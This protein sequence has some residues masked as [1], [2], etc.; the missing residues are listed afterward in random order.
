M[1]KIKCPECGCDI[2]RDAAK[3]PFC[4]FVIKKENIS[5][6]NN[7]T[8]VRNGG[9]RINCKI[10]GIVA[11]IASVVLFACAFSR[12]NNSEY[13]F[14]KEYYEDCMEG[15]DNSKYSARTEGL[16]FSGAYTMIA[17]EYKDMASENKQKLDHFRLQAWIFGT[18]GG[19]LLIGGFVFA[20][21]KEK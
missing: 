5:A 6:V 18:L 11:I 13:K 16:L 8:T 19:I 4:D 12:I 7:Y 14:Y 2:S 9:H 20:Y 1:E 17:D 21:K 3:C 15:Y 10:I